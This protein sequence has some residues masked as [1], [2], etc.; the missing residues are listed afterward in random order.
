MIP[1]KRKYLYGICIS[2]LMK[3]YYYIFYKN[4]DNRQCHEMIKRQLF[5]DQIQLVLFLYPLLYHVYVNRF[6]YFDANN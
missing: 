4:F 5:D 2:M 3:R 1:R 6:I